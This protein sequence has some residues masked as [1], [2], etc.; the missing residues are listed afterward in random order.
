MPKLV[1]RPH[2]GAAEWAVEARS[3]LGDDYGRPRLG[4]ISQYIAAEIEQRT[5]IATRL[6]ILGH[7][8]RGG[9]PTAF[10]RILATQLGIAAIDLASEGR[11]G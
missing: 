9:T 8:R 10:G 2:N 6:T 7:V 1:A 4:G 11:W 5:G 3:G